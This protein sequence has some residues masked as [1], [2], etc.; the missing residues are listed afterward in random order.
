MLLKKRHRNKILK[1]FKK[2]DTKD[3]N[4]LIKEEVIKSSETIEI[5]KKLEGNENIKDIFYNEEVKPKNISKNKINN[6]NTKYS[7]INH[8]NNTNTNTNNNSN[9]N[10]TIQTIK[11]DKKMEDN[12]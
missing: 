5:I 2:K 6:T 10:N 12:I 8:I 7:N 4:K 11:I 1:S 9:A 3:K